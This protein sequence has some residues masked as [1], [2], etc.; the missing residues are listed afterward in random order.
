MNQV[1]EKNTNY[2]YNA[3]WSKTVFPKNFIGGKSFQWISS[4]LK[5]SW[6]GGPSSLL[7]DVEYIQSR[8][9]GSHIESEQK[10][11]S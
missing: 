2:K 4:I 10:V 11:R 8:T 1:L 3:A 6:T 9:P 5:T 7:N